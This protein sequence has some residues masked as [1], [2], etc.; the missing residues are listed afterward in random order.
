MPTLDAALSLSSR[1]VALSLLVQTF[2][3]IR[4]RES[5]SSVGIW[6]PAHVSAH[7]G[8]VART[9]AAETSFV[10]LL[11]AQL[12]GAGASVVIG[13]SPLLL[14]LAVTYVLV[15]LRF[16][17]PFNGGSDALTLLSLACLGVA[18]CGHAQALLTKVAVCYLVAQLAL[19]Y[20]IAGLAK[21]KQPS[22]RSGVALVS[23]VALP[24]YAAPALARAWLARPVIAKWAARGV[25][26]FECSF[27]LA[28]LSP[29]L[30]WAYLLLGAAFHV[31][32]AA[33]LGLN[34]FLWAW[35]ALYPLLLWLSQ[36]GP[37]A[38]HSF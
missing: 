3:L 13:P 30:C 10:G 21:L 6:R 35:L 15:A 26:A 19:S 25:L 14:A 17:G 31:A 24:K 20:F 12:G 27:P 34:R 29:T 22:W 23:F 11:V 16:T 37:L 8:K 32:N 33:V 18:S 2:E 4:L 7:A 9:F 28:L 36:L 5:F 38:S 1:L